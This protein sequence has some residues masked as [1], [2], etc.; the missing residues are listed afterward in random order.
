M[1]GSIKSARSNFK[2]RNGVVNG[3]GFCNCHCNGLK[4]SDRLIKHEPGFESIDQYLF[5]LT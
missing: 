4:N 3:T 1:G 2:N 5:T